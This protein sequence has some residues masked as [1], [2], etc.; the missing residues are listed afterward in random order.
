MKKGLL[1]AAIIV[2]LLAIFLVYYFN[3]PGN[4]EN[5]PVTDAGSSSGNSVKLSEPERLD[6]MRLALAEME[7][8]NPATA[9]PL[10]TQLVS[11]DPASLDAVQN[12]TLNRLSQ[13]AEGVTALNGS[14][15]SEAEIAAIRQSLPKWIAAARESQ[16]RFAELVNSASSSSEGERAV[17]SQWIRAQV[18]YLTMRASGTDQEGQNGGVLP[19]QDE[20]VGYLKSNPTSIIL[21]GAIDKFAQETASLDGRPAEQ[22]RSLSE[23]FSAAANAIPDNIYLCKTALGFAIEAEED[24]ALALF[25]RLEKLALPLVPE[26]S[27]ALG[28]APDAVQE[29]IAPLRTALVSKNFS[30]AS[31]YFS[32]WNNIL[33]P[34]TV[35]KS[36]RKKA[37]VNLLDLVAT[38]DFNNLSRK[39]A[40]TSLPPSHDKPLLFAPPQDLPV[41]NNSSVRAIT[42]VDA[43]LQGAPEIAA[44]SDEGLTI[45]RLSGNAWELFAE[46]SIAPGTRGLTMADLF[47]VDGAI[48]G[49]VERI[50]RIISQ[51]TNSSGEPSATNSADA[52]NQTGSVGKDH[53]T[54]PC[55]LA[56]GDGGIQI[57]R[58]DGREDTAIAERLL[59]P[60]EPTG[61]EKIKQVTALTVGDIDADGDLDLLIA[62]EIDGVSLW[63]NRGNMTF[64]DLTTY[65]SMPDAADPVVYFAIGDI[66]RDLDLDVAT[67]QRS[68]KVGYLENVL[69]MQMRWRELTSAAQFNSG[70]TISI[71]EWDGNVS[72]D[73]IHNS[74]DALAL[75]RTETT[76]AGMLQ[77]LDSQQRPL[78]SIAAA[79]T[80][81]SHITDLDNDSWSDVVLFGTGGIQVV[82]GGPQE[83]QSLP[84][85]PISP[86]AA[87]NVVVRDFDGDG[88]S[89]ILQ[90]TSGRVSFL[91]NQTE[92]TGHFLDVHFIGIDDNASGRVNHY[93]IGSTLELRFGP[94]Y[95]ATVITDRLSRFGLGNSSSADAM[96]AILPNGI[97]Q[98]VIKPPLDTR[99]VEEQTLKGSCP[100]LYAWDGEQYAFVTDCLW[101][102]P[103]GL[104]AALGK[105]IPDRPWEYIKVDG[106]FVQPKDGHYELR[107]TEELWE[108]AYF[109]HVAL[110]AVDHP[111]GSDIWTNEKVGPPEVVQPR[112]FAFL[113]ARPVVSARDTSGADVSELLRDADEQYVQGFPQRI[114][115]GLCPTHWIE[116]ELGQVTD[117]APLFLLLTGW[118]FPT[119]TSLN[120]QIDQNPELPSVQPPSVW[121]PDGEGGWQES[122]AAMG[123]PGGKTKTI[124]VELTGKINPAD[125]RVRIQTNAQIYWDAAQIVVDPTSVETKTH[126]LVLTDATVGYRGFS[127]LAPRTNTQPHRYDYSQVDTG[128]KWPPLEGHVTQMG[129]CRQLLDSWD[130]AMV[131]LGSGD[132]IRLRFRVPDEPVPA[133]WQRDF[134]LHSVGWDK[135]ADLNTLAGQSVGPLPFREMESYP[136]P[137]TQ[138]EMSRNVEALNARQLNRRQNFRAFWAR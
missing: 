46:Q 53:D 88:R 138:A 1:V 75:W 33:T 130:N 137:F 72:W 39:L 31:L 63:F 41:P 24:Q 132:E 65:S 124:V 89:D 50:N 122:I 115:Q 97:T 98:N 22:A 12:W 58:V 107:L 69:H 129:D 127:A 104:Q 62:S 45:Y 128:P 90:L 135:D 80:L 92:S 125:P 93:A 71:A 123:F 6:L 67:L 77:S 119:D 64:Y 111:Q 26:L 86:V 61:L 34:L 23:A 13:L 109:D 15:K 42:A 120:I 94:H 83:L 43:D 110:I 3:P 44:A 108:L 121:I 18:E 105:V 101:A 106:R 35:V 20:L 54:F 16:Q 131:V 136:P 117:G 60:T 74:R 21:A 30:D 118:I 40:A 68:G 66:D 103:L 52:T 4:A 36:D 51:E 78:N 59:P 133:G 91:R 56:W 114:V 134:I 116:L 100:F 81:G 29:V 70:G 112:T 57:F 79:D 32:Q 17:I 49:R 11:D 113:N 126:P 73:V 47:V 2:G 9:D 38:K 5:D 99:I 7:N 95:R 55:L 28:N 10:W 14:N 25:D 82:R 96:R 48:A 76:G 8:V 87:E 27:L 85:T 102:A 19:V 37:D 84:L